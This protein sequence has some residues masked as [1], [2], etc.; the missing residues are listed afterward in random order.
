MDQTKAGGQL[1]LCVMREKVGE[2]VGTEETLEKA[3]EVPGAWP[4]ETDG[5][6]ETRVLGQL[7]TLLISRRRK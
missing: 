4:D 2:L 5:N 6:D 3:G 1:L 7:C